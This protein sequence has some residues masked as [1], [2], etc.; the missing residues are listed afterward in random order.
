[1]EPDDGKVRGDLRPLP[2]LA[3]LLLA[4]AIPASYFWVGY[5]R[6]S[7]AL[8]TELELNAEW[9]EQALTGGRPRTAVLRDLVRNR[10]RAVAHEVRRVLD[11]DRKVIVEDGEPLAPPVLSRRLTLRA[12]GMAGFLEIRRSLRPL[13]ERAA[14]LGLV[15]AVIAPFFYALLWLYPFRAARLALERDY[16]REESLGD[17][18]RSL[19]LLTATLESTD[20]GILVTDLYGSV[21][22]HNRRYLELWRLPH[23]ASESSNEAF[24]H[25]VKQMQRPYPFV[26][27]MKKLRNEQEREFEMVVELKD[28]RFI[29]CRSRPQRVE[30][31]AV[32]RVWMFRDISEHRRA[33]ALLTTEEL[34]LRSIVEGTTLPEVLN[35]LTQYV[36]ERSGRL[37]AAIYLTDR[38][39]EH[40]RSI[41]AP[42]LPQ[43][44]AY[45][46]GGPV[47]DNPGS[48]LAPA[49]EQTEPT[50]SEDLAT[51]PHWTR[52]RQTA[53]RLGLSSTWSVPILSQ[54][55]EALGVFCA[56][57]RDPGMPEP[58]DR[59][60]AK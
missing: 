38:E 42:S 11:G 46:L 58:Y 17:V 30:G 22:R 54:K 8:I 53:L 32:G 31:H 43:Q 15:S 37:F 16:L 25:I 36:E 18:R 2:L 6:V 52:N 27:E 34:V 35:R 21:I 10:P 29:D 50:A 19:S 44:F 5:E 23:G 59:E 4:L 14:L 41:S 1:M 39:G 57:F 26:V 60:L 12:E 33:E 20:D 51:D 9:A 55:G 47:R 48:P 7:A 56:F 49:L 24:S 28:G 3:T 40:L 13:A 45:E